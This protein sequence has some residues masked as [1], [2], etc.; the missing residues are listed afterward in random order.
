MGDGELRT[1]LVAG[2]RLL[3]GWACVAVALLDL[4]MGPVK[5]LYLVFHLVL[6]VGGLLL[7]R[8]PFKPFEYAVITGL[9]VVTTVVAALPS[10]SHATCCMSALDIRH[11]YPLALLGWD[12]GQPAHFAPA[13]TF[14]DLAFWFLAWMTLGA[15]VFRSRSSSSSPESHPTHAED[16]AA[17]AATPPAAEAATPPAAQAAAPP[18]A[19]AAPAGPGASAAAQSASSPASPVTTAA[20]RPTTARAASPAEPAAPAAASPAASPSA[21]PAGADASGGEDQ[22]QRAGDESVGGLP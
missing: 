15:V 16:R 3:C 7:L 14:A 5:D 21:S 8:K 1:T 17:E 13:H 2:A 19:Q 4:T 22:P 11:G 6:L 9:A 18:A 12:R 10:T 20:A